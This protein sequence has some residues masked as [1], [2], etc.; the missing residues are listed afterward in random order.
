MAGTLREDQ[1]AVELNRLLFSGEKAKDAGAFS[2]AAS[3]DGVG[4]PGY[5]D[6]VEIFGEGLSTW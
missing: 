1:P 4:M 6:V 5:P 3:P 2:K